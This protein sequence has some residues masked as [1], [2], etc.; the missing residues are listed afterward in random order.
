[1]SKC[2]YEWNPGV[3]PYTA[4]CVL[5][6]GHDGGHVGVNHSTDREQERW[7]DES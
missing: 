7:E 6:K 2:K 1:M 3:W 5:E 4:V